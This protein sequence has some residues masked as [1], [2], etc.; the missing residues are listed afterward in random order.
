MKVLGWTLVD[1]QLYPSFSLSAQDQ[2]SEDYDW[3]DRYVFIGPLQ[4]LWRKP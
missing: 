3:T 2:P 4:T 1:W